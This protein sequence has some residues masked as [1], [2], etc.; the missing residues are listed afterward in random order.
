MT[1]IR[2]ASA[3]LRA[4]G[5]RAVRSRRAGTCHGVREG[6]VLGNACRRL[7]RRRDQQPLPDRLLPAGA[8]EHARRRS[9]LPPATTSTARSRAAW[10]RSLA[11]SER[12][13]ASQPPV[14]A[15]VAADREL[16]HAARALR[17]ACRPAPRGR[18]GRVLHAEEM[19]RRRTPPC[20]ERLILLLRQ[21]TLAAVVAAV[22]GFVTPTAGAPPARSSDPRRCVAAQRSLAL[23][24]PADSTAS[25]WT[26][27]ASRRWD[28]IAVRTA[29]P[30][31]NRRPRHRWR[32]PDRVLSRR[33]IAAVVTLVGTP[34]WANGGFD[35]SWAPSSPTAFADFATPP[36]AATR[37]SATGRSGTSPTRRGGSSPR[38]RR[39][40]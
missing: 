19:E 30:T 27:S 29:R 11:G 13:G 7:E 36:R 12:D 9:S 2:K 31:D 16:R 23:G 32:N 5:V 37:S 4:A 40:T 6:G 25:V 26:S 34:S 10:W 18:R 28:Q 15:A 8:Q 39:S 24:A 3:Y 38:R 35:A 33:G 17:I 21:A 20:A 14:A 22:A 1:S